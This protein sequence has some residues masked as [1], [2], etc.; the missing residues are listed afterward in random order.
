MKA[1][2]PELVIRPH[3]PMRRLL[4]VTLCVLG[5]VGLGVAFELGQYRAGYNIVSAMQQRAQLR[6][7]IASLE[8]ANRS[9][10]TRIIAL[11]TVNAGHAR[12]DQVVGRTIGDLQTRVARQTEELAFYRAVV[13][14]GAPA[15]GLR[16]GTVRLSSSKPADN[17]LADVSLVRAGKTDGMTTG[18]VSLTVDGQAAGGKPMTLDGQALAA[19]G[20][21]DVPYDFRYYQDLHQTIVLPPGFRPD[22]L[23]VK[24]SSGHKDVPPLIQTFP[25]S[26]V[27]V[28]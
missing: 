21:A 27:A 15:I 12:E 6:K 23:T 19:G 28:P 22:R 2:P 7:A 8:S 18:T 17:Y 26:A 11:E 10:Q 5:L 14:E 4:G 16:V 25:W 9:L 20:K 3:A 24:V 1:G 13:A